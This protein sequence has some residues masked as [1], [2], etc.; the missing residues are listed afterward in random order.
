M[1]RILHIDA[2]YSSENSVS[3]VLSGAFITAWKKFHPEDVILYR[4]LGHFPVPYI[5]ETWIT[6]VHSP[7]ET[8][9]PE[10]V[11]AL[12]VSNPLLEEFLSVDCYVFGIPMYGFTIPA[13]LKAYIEHLIQIG[14]TYEVNENGV[15]GLVQGKKALFITSRGGNYLPGSP[16]GEDHQEPYLRTIFWSFGITD[17]QFVNASNLVLRDREK[18]ISTAQAHLQTLAAQW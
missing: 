8:H 15:Q 3:R 6:A 1:R 9:T 18:S 5:N 2:S 11:E 13:T 10:M 14:R 17:V 7:P 4:D 16:F 12:K